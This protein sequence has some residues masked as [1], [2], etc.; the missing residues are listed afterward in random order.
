MSQFILITAMAMIGMTALWV[1]E[2]GSAAAGENGTNVVDAAV[3]RRSCCK[4]CKC[5]IPRRLFSNCPFK[6]QSCQKVEFEAGSVCPKGFQK[7][8]IVCPIGRNCNTNVF[9]LACDAI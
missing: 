1:G 6:S 5:N 7:H 8:C 2:I 3:V 4:C 9:K